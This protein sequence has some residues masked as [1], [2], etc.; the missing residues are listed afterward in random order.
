MHKRRRTV[1]CPILGD[2]NSEIYGK[3]LVILYGEKYMNHRKD[4]N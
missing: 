4:Y 3:T 1:F 2:N